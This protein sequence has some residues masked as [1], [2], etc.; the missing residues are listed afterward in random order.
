MAIQDARVQVTELEKNRLVARAQSESVAL[1]QLLEERRKQYHNDLVEARKAH[2]ETS[3]VGRAATVTDDPIMTT[4]SDAAGLHE[5][6]YETDSFDSVSSLKMPMDGV[7]SSSLHVPVI[8]DV[9][10][11]PTTLPHVNANASSD[12]ISE[13][14]PSTK[15]DSID[16][17]L[18]EH[19]TQDRQD[20]DDDS[21]FE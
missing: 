5:Q 8:A 7:E 15:S 12:S 14:L 9:V 4:A 18:S 21:S 10:D 16:H 2:F 17:V 19:L 13:I 20:H 11:A 1:V 6:V 3:A